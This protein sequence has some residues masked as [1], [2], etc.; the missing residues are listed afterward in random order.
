MRRA[1]YRFFDAAFTVETDSAGF[2]AH[3][4]RAYARFRVVADSDAPVY[5]VRLTGCPEVELDGETWR[6]TDA[7]ALG[8]YAYNAI[9]NAA[10]ARVG[11]HFLFHAAALAAPAG[12]GIILSG[13]AGLGKT[14]LTLAL[15]RRGYRLH[16]DDV[17]AVG[18]DDGLL[19]PFPRSLGVRDEGGRPGEKRLLDV[20]E[21]GPAVL[22][23]QAPSPPR[24]LF[25]L[26]EGA[27]QPQPPGCALVLDRVTAPFLAELAAL[28]GVRAATVM[29][30]GL[31][32]VVA[33]DLAAGASRAFEPAV[34]AACRRHT[35]LLFDIT[36]GPAAPPD[37]GAAPRLTRLS[38]AEATPGLLRHLKGGPSSALLAGRFGGRA[39]RLYMAL[40]A[41]AGRMTCYRLDVGQL[42]ASVA[43]I[44]VA[45]SQDGGGSGC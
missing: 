5:R 36:D 39:A 37:F 6:A 31:C 19:Y 17:A 3:F 34:Q 18:C 42:E 29:R 7:A 28:P 44:Q 9:L 20:S 40:A 16:S 41:L 33:V 1:A 10:T 12:A 4:D 43:L 13:G 21:L 14:T 38:P 8:L 45:V 25:L 27:G 35:L 24:L 2:L 11:S 23:A 22:L 15:L 30:D 32:L 26:A